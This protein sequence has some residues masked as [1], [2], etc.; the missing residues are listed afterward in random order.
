MCKGKRIAVIGV[1]GY[2]VFSIRTCLQLSILCCQKIQMQNM[3]V[4]LMIGSS[5]YPRALLTDH[6]SV[7]WFDHHLCTDIDVWVNATI[8][9][10]ILVQ[11]TEAN[12]SRFPLLMTIFTT[13]TETMFYRQD[14]YSNS[15]EQRPLY[16]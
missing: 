13:D 4:K 2:T 5:S 12:T 1:I 8:S 7:V 10:A 14:F 16:H 11:C 3:L 9:F 15:H 6:S